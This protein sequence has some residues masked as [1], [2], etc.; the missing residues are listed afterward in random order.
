MKYRSVTGGFVALLIGLV[1]ISSCS[2]TAVYKSDQISEVQNLKTDPAVVV[3]VHD[4]YIN[5]ENDHLKLSPFLKNALISKLQQEF[6]GRVK[7]Y[8]QNRQISPVTSRRPVVLF[9]DIYSDLSKHSGKQTRITRKSRSSRGYTESWDVVENQRLHKTQLH[10]VVNLKVLNVTQSPTQTSEM[11]VGQQEK[12][13][14]KGD[15]GSSSN[16]QTHHWTFSG[17]K[18]VLKFTL[19]DNDT[20]FSI[21]GGYS[22]V[23]F[24]TANANLNAKLKQLAVEIVNAL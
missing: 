7:V 6:P 5:T 11:S 10:A 16:Y 1:A 20:S 2:Q 4:K 23:T 18:K 12:I 17:D 22:N 15:Q 14:L 8:S 21:D 13:T 9:L 24:P 19:V 3:I